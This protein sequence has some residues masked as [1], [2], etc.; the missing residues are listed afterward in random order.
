[1]SSNLSGVREWLIRPLEEAGRVPEG[2]FVAALE[3]TPNSNLIKVAN[4]RR[5]AARRSS[6]ALTELA[7]LAPGNMI[8]EMLGVS[9]DELRKILYGKARPSDELLAKA[10]ELLPYVKKNVRLL[11]FGEERPPVFK[12]EMFVDRTLD[13]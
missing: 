2:T 11:L 13:Y 5:A 3:L 7:E 9:G 1:M 12:A 8:S 6:G 10:A 4:A